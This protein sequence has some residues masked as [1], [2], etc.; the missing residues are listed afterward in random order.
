MTIHPRKSPLNYGTS[1]SR[2]RSRPCH[3]S[4][5]K[6]HSP[7]SSQPHTLTPRRSILNPSA[8]KRRKN[9]AY[10]LASTPHDPNKKVYQMFI[11]DS[12]GSG[13]SQAALEV[14]TAIKGVAQVHVFSIFDFC[15]HLPSLGICS[16][17]R[18][19][20]SKFDWDRELAPSN[21]ANQRVLSGPQTPPPR[22]I[23]TSFS[24]LYFRIP[25]NR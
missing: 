24:Y 16:G 18:P 15:C 22:A 12:P 2:F 17:P 7:S 8:T 6:V 1:E 3:V 5:T 11:E 21:D 13:I 25:K 20:T 14:H 19:S 23:F 9:P 10:G 4:F